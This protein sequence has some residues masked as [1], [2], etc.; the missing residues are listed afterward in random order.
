MVSSRLIFIPAF[1]GQPLTFHAYPPVHVD[2]LN[3]CKKI[4]YSLHFKRLLHKA[5]LCIPLKIIIY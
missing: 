5:R 1:Y 2:F 4:Y 3:F